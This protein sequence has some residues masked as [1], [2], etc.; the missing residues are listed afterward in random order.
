ME[1]FG[2]NILGVIVATFIGMILGALWYSPVLFGKQWMNCI[3]KTP[4]SLGS[5]T[6]P[7]IGSIIASLM[8]AIGISLIFSLIAVESLSQGIT[9]G[10]TLGVLIIFPAMLSDSLFCGWG[11]RLLIIQS[12]YRV[13]SVLLMSIALVY[14]V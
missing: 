9:V 14:I 8:T 5:A 13:I 1:I 2:L 11:N 4:E 6:G 12:G 7:M 10:L 3:G